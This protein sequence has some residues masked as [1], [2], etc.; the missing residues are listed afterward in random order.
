MFVLMGSINYG[1]CLEGLS[2]LV[3][4]NHYDNCIIVV[5][6]ILNQKGLYC[7]LLHN[8]AAIF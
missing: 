2:L 1:H 7:L 6:D 3:K 8:I 4:N 5:I